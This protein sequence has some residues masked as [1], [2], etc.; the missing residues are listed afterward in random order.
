MKVYKINTEFGIGYS[1]GN[2]GEETNYIDSAGNKLRVGDVAQAEACGEASNAI[3]AEDE[4]CGYTLWGYA[5]SNLCDLKAR[6][7][8]DF[9]VMR[10]TYREQR[11]YVL[12]EEEAALVMFVRGLLDK[13]L[14]DDYLNKIT[15]PRIR[16]HFK[17]KEV[18]RQELEEQ[19]GGKLWGGL[20]E[21]FRR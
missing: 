8:R 5:G 6:K 17:E 19:E 20:I 16:K 9:D 2:F 3:V 21:L 11:A 18:A 12:H 13:R 7:V 15:L 4:K 14:N 10:D 1:I